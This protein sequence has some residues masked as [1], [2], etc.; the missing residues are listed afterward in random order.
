MDDERKSGRRT[1]E[2]EGSRWGRRWRVGVKDEKRARVE[3]MGPWVSVR[4]RRSPI[5]VHFEPSTWSRRLGAQKGA[6]LRLLFFNLAP[7]RE[8]VGPVRPAVI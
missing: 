2:K 6:H 8:G 4:K 7:R 5:Y 1:M 3:R